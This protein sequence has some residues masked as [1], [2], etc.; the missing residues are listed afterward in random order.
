M[1]GTYA[2]FLLIMMFGAQWGGEGMRDY[3]HR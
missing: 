2:E 3:L 1:M